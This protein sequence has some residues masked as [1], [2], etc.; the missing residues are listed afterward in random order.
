MQIMMEIKLGAGRH[1][2]FNKKNSSWRKFTCFT[3]LG[4]QILGIPKPSPTPALKTSSLSALQITTIVKVFL[5]NTHTPTYGSGSVCV[6]FVSCRLTFVIVLSRLWLQQ[7]PKVG[8]LPLLSAGGTFS[9]YSC[10]QNRIC[11][12]ISLYAV[13]CHTKMNQT[14]AGNHERF[15]G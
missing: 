10:F 11:F 12:T 1:K 8:S 4:W 14:S 15:A 6:S 5:F 3:A 7:N 2:Q 13:G 9:F